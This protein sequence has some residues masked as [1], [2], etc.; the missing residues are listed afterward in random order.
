MNVAQLLPRRE[1]APT[2]PSEPAPARRAEPPRAA[3]FLL[4]VW[5]HAYVQQFLDT[6][7]PT[8]L[9]P[10]N[11]PAVAAALPC[12]FIIMTSR[13]DVAA[14]RAHPAYQRLAQVCRTEIRPID[15]LIT[16]SNVS[17][18][19]TLA[20]TEEVRASGAGMVDICFFFLVSDYIVADGAFASVLARIMRGASGVLAGNFQ[21]VAEDALP[22][23][24]DRL[25]R[26]PDM[27]ALTSR[28][29]MGWAMA[30]PHPATVANIVNYPVT[31]NDHTNRLFWR[32]DGST[33][34]GR[35]FLM[36]MI[37]V[38]PE[39]SEFLIASSC[40]YSFIPEMCPSGNVEIITD[41][42][43]YAVIET[44]PRR[45]EG[46]FLR[47]GPLQPRTLARTLSEWT[48][49]RHRAN[50][51]HPVFFH[52][53][54]LP[55]GTGGAL[56]EFE[57]F[58]ARVLRRL[59]P[60]PRPH[61]W[62]PYWL[63]AI[64]AFKD[65]IG[66]RLS[67][68]EWLAVL[69]FYPEGRRGRLVEWLAR[70]KRRAMFAQPP[71]VRPWHPQWPDQRSVLK[72]LQPFLVDRN[73]RLLLIS[74]NP[75]VYTASLSDGGERVVRYRTGVFLTARPDVHAPLA[76]HFDT[77]LIELEESELECAGGLIDHVTP[78]VCDGGV[79]LVSVRP[80]WNRPAAHLVDG[81]VDHAPKFLR[82]DA[83]S[84]QAKFIP[85]NPLRRATLRSVV[86]LARLMRDRP[87]VGLPTALLVG[88]AL[89][90]ASLVAGLADGRSHAAPRPRTKYSSALFTL[91]VA[92]GTQT[93]DAQQYAPDPKVR[94]AAAARIYA[95]APS[96][97]PVAAEGGTREPQ[98]NRCLEIDAAHGRTPLGLMT[99]QVWH[100]DPRRLTFLLARYKF[101]AKMLAGRDSVAEV[102]CGDA[103]GT[104]I[105]LQAVERVTAYDFDPVF[106]AD[107][108]RRFSERWPIEAHVHDAL[109]GPLPA[110]YDAVYSLDVLEH[111]PRPDEQTF[112]SNLAASLNEAGTLVIGTPSLESQA[113]ASPPSKAGH[114][115]CKSGDELKALLERTF[116]N[117]FL[118]SMNDEV[119][120]TGFAPMAHYLFVVC[121]GRRGSP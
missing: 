5:G 58:M 48:T 86:R 98:Y 21:I 85:A 29:L 99:N 79:V 19:I 38:R 23:L 88:P 39:V 51:G 17:T 72:A 115:N 67:L 108:R 6:G 103:F 82:P 14:I 114:V 106:I 43:E 1:P 78:L 53:G 61:R 69:G 50:A 74:T 3:K 116:H 35:F 121:T 64:A 28:E 10:G 62:H 16:G 32:V 93:L 11:V 57:T 120:H 31:H 104:R 65:A 91:R 100:D 56:A 54:E 18:T 97:T 25:G 55:A 111:I 112:I 87:V 80:S 117:V 119:V 34:I 75:T 113:H 68:E 36:H 44:Q 4:P 7:L 89:G 96:D 52:A 90:A 70:Q 42:D 59:P 63:G 84:L 41:S 20:Y 33:L 24:R 77:C 60:R 9:A 8:L 66:R 15:H 118:F 45:H 95:A 46:A 22:W 73:H 49:A 94:R 12:D 40:D 37:A 107:I 71:R 27:L 13:N 76:G 101:V 81:I 2:A 47:P 105:V 92:R 26:S 110:R 109:A 102:G 83:R 30:H